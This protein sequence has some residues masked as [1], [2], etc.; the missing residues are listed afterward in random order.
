MPAQTGLTQLGDALL[1]GSGDYAN[2]QLR[3]QQEERLRNNQLTDLAD[4]RR[5]GEQQANAGVERQKGMLTWQQRQARI[6]ELIAL[7]FLAEA[8]A[9]NEEAVAFADA[10]ATGRTAGMRKESD[11]SDK[12]AK[13][14]VNDIARQLKDLDTETKDVQGKLSAIPDAPVPPTTAEV[15][16]LAKQIAAREKADYKND[17]VRMQFQETARAQLEKKAQMDLYFLQ[18]KAETYRQILQGSRLR[19]DALN[20]QLSDFARRKILPTIKPPP[21]ASPVSGLAAPQTSGPREASPEERAA[22]AGGAAGP[23][24][25]T[26]MASPAESLQD[27][28]QYGGVIGAMRG[29]GRM[30]GNAAGAVRDTAA[31]IPGTLEMMVGGDK[32]FQQREAQRAAPLFSLPSSV[33]SWPFPQG[34]GQT[35]QA[36]AVQRSLAQPLPPVRTIP[37]RPPSAVFANPNAP[38]Y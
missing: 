26:A 20:S 28:S 16:R 15:D 24:T 7:G 30:V 27:P 35:P 12:E 17:A 29:A 25:T 22:A 36:N 13:V 4:A 32:L 3:R 1:R 18:Q 8:D 19:F 31:L 23:P 14:Y 34:T 6:R 9:A 11:D 38:T 2:I 33:P 10:A 21:A 37:Y 5:Y